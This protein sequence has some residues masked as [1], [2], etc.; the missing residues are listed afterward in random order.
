VVVL[1]FFYDLSVR[2]T[3]AR[4]GVS[5][6]TVKSQTHRA[7]ALLRDRLGLDVVEEEDEDEEELHH[8]R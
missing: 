3:A 4:L 6:G 7:V 8:A 1:R 2:D 5:E